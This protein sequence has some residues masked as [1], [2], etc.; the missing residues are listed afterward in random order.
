MQH[1]RA[2]QVDVQSLARSLA[3]RDRQLDEARALEH[4]LRAE[5]QSR[6]NDAC[7]RD[8]RAT[9]EL[10]QEGMA[11][12]HLRSE[13]KEA[14]AQLKVAYQAVTSLEG[15][16]TLEREARAEEM[17]VLKRD[18]H[19]DVEQFR[20]AAF[21]A[22]A[23]GQSDIEELQAQLL[24]TH[25]QGA[26]LVQ[27]LD[28]VD[29]EEQRNGKLLQDALEARAN[30]VEELQSEEWRRSSQR[31][32]GHDTQKRLAEDFKFRLR[33][34]LSDCETRER[35]TL[36]DAEAE[37]QA[38]FAD[39]RAREEVTSLQL[40]E[41][42]S[43]I[44]LLQQEAEDLRAMLNPSPTHVEDKPVFSSAG[45][46][47]LD[48]QVQELE[49]LAVGLEREVGSL[50]AEVARL[51]EQADEKQKSAEVAVERE[52]LLRAEAL[53]DFAEVKHLHE[54][55]ERL[56][57]QIRGEPGEASCNRVLS[58]DPSLMSPVSLSPSGSLYLSDEAQ[59][60]GNTSDASWLLSGAP[61][62]EALA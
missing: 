43:E 19:E 24:D 22:Q 55:H 26:R 5:L 10:H 58:P 3:Q 18:C 51:Q 13:T 23:R 48:E 53:R 60:A 4:L 45:V 25:M 38:L 28:A 7:N 16:L 42:V 8:E 37:A 35:A 62:Q 44:H 27:E 31:Q 34:V 12:Q 1:N 39:F 49:V 50:T 29:N 46:S 32:K 14:E 52:D 56:R 40:Q 36:K 47:E 11:F 57:A 20:Q 2:L 54:D 6:Q 30:L 33:E 9:V 41:E 59:G 17:K 61:A 21:A 15:R